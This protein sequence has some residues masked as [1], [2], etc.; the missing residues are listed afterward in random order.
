M[1]IFYSNTFQDARRLLFSVF[2]L[3]FFLVLR[4]RIR[5]T[6]FS[7]HGFPLIFFGLS[8]F[9][10]GSFLDLTDELAFFQDY[11]LLGQTNESHE[12]LED[13]VGRGFGFVFFMVGL[14]LWIPAFVRSHSAG[15]TRAK[16]ETEE[17]KVR[18]EEAYHQLLTLDRLKDDFM[19]SVSHELRTPLTSI[20]SFSEI[21]LKYEDTRPETAREFLSIINSESQRLTRLINNVLD[22]SRIEAGQMIWHD[23]FVSLDEVAREMAKV[24]KGLLENKS[25]QIQFEFLNPFPLVYA[26]RD[27]VSQVITNLLGNAIK[28][29]KEGGKILIRGERF[30]EE[31]RGKATLWTKI[32]ISDEGVEIDPAEYEV[33]FNKF[34]QSSQSILD[35]RPRGTGLGLP[36]CKEIITHYGGRIWVENKGGKEKG[37]VFYFTLPTAPRQESRKQVQEARS[38]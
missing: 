23:D 30:E 7:L 19:S 27:R 12:M 21:L 1:Q 5:S 14:L 31:Q 36:I 18:L 35:S 11:A 37:S 26:D 33:I 24:H 9:C 6:G 3:L 8:L 25:L 17:A 16:K 2:T 15:V 13:L 22:L 20:Q 29:S 38:V 4:F 32:G 10:L 28:F 34:Q